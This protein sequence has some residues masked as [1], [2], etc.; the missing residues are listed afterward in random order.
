MPFLWRVEL[1]QPEGK[2]RRVEHEGLDL[3]EK[4]HEGQGGEC[5]KREKGRASAAATPLPSPDGPTEEMAQG[6]GSRGAPENAGTRE[7]MP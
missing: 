4:L 2:E 7:P 5:G 1:G 3:Q 6:I